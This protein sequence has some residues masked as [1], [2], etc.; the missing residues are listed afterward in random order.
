MLNSRIVIS[1]AVGKNRGEAEP[2]IVLDSN[3]KG[4]NQ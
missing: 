1:L 4:N 2:K 3:V